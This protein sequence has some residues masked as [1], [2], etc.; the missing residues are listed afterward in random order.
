MI[1]RQVIVTWYDPEEKLPEEDT[2]VIAT[3]SGS[4]HGLTLSR[5]LLTMCYCKSEGWYSPDLQIDDITVH[6]WCDLEPYKGG[7]SND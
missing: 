4:G 5:T 3:V 6:G 1:E 2:I 7:D